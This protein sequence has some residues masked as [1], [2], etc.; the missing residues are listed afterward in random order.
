M[1]G[2]TPRGIKSRIHIGPG[3]LDAPAFIQTLTENEQC[4]LISPFQGPTAHV[5][6]F[7]LSISKTSARC[8]H[9]R[10][11]DGEKEK[12]IK[13]LQTL[14]DA[15]SRLPLDR[16]TLVIALGGGTLT[17]KAALAASLYQRGL[18][19]GMIPTTLLSMVDAAVGGKTAINLKGG[20]N[21]AGTFLEPE[22]VLLDPTVLTTLPG[23]EWCN[24]RAEWLKLALLKGGKMLDDLLLEDVARVSAVPGTKALAAV[25]RGKASFISN[26]LRDQTGRRAML[27]LGHT[28]G[29]ALETISGH[30]TS[31]GR[32]VAIGILFALQVSE[33]LLNL[34]PTCRQRITE[35]YRI[36]NLPCHPRGNPAAET[37]MTLMQRD[38]KILAGKIRLVLLA[39]PGDPQLVEVDPEFLLEA[40][41]RFLN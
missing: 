13:G 33:Q 2:F 15:M 12:S 8:H 38:K 36:N 5:E 29:H 18:R 11:A 41:Q 22:W 40:L 34:D 4:L 19:L 24:G 23:R 27:N 37:L 35:W 28:L 20:K 6:R 9:L 26:D 31:H 30:R 7:L 10:I 21:L 32:A 1:I 3:L 39:A 16:H 17:D 14:L 25:I